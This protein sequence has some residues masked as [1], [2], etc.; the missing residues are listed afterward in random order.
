MHDL[1][2]HEWVATNLNREFDLDP[3]SD[4]SALD[5]V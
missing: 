2:T 3:A 1:M 4:D 5:I